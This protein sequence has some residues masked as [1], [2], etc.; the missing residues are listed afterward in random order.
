MVH[1]MLA[2]LLRIHRRGRWWRWR[3]VRRCESLRRLDLT[4]RNASCG[5]IPLVGCGWVAVWKLLGPWCRQPKRRSILWQ[6]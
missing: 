5:R 4:K 2:D 1:S 6:G 3:L